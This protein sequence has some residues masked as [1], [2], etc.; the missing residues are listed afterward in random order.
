MKVN[1]ASQWI[2]QL[3]RRLLARNYV[4]VFGPREVEGAPGRFEAVFIARRVPLGMAI[5]SR[6]G[7]VWIQVRNVMM[8]SRCWVVGGRIDDRVVHRMSPT[9]VDR[10][11][12]V[13]VSGVDIILDSAYDGPCECEARPLYIVGAVV[14]MRGDIYDCSFAILLMHSS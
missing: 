8:G 3:E 14:V 10:P 9:L 5:S 7:T 6:C 4:I 13:P 11:R 2:S 12:C 1:F